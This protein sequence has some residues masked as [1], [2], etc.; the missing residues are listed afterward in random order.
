MPLVTGRHIAMVIGPGVRRMAGRGLVSNRGVGRLI[1]MGA[2]SITTTRGFGSRGVTST[3]SE[4]GGGPRSSPLSILVFHS[5]TTFA[6]IHCRTTSAIH[7]HAIIDVTIRIMA[8]VDVTDVM[9]VTPAGDVTDV[10]D[11]MDVTPAGDETDAMDAMDAMDAKVAQ[12]EVVDVIRYRHVMEKDVTAKVDRS[13][14]VPRL[15]V[16]RGKV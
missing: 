10:T 1:T 12:A 5:V 4:A 6:G 2:G 8:A 7:I 3:R 11:A 13:V 15:T 14:M 9:D 16:R